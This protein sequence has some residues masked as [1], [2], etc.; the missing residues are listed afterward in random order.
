MS[1]A[2]LAT[3]LTVCARYVEFRRASAVPLQNCS[4]K[5]A[6]RFRSLVSRYARLQSQWNYACMCNVKGSVLHHA[7]GAVNMGR[8]EVAL[9]Q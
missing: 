2:K 8:Q 9:L 5:A 3:A 7:N 4:K 1:E 6:N